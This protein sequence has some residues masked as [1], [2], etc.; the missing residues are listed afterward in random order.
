MRPKSE[1]LPPVVCIQAQAVQV[2]RSDR[3]VLRC[4]AFNVRGT[5]EGGSFQVLRV[6]KLRRWSVGEGL[7]I[8]IRAALHKLLI[9]LTNRSSDGP[10]RHGEEG[11]ES[12]EVHVEVHLQ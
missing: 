9:R 6:A 1:R 12:R 11:K 4:T 2:V 3:R 5:H 7:V 10:N 8:A